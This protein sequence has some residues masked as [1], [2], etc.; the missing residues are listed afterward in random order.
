M[1]GK[2]WR[3]GGE[4]E[5]RKVRVGLDGGRKPEWVWEMDGWVDASVTD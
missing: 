2:E 1:D 4:E 3:K 5:R